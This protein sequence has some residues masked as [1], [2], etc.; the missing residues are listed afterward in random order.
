MTDYGLLMAEINPLII[1]GDG[2]FIALDGK[3]EVDDNFVDLT[4]EME[5]FY[6]REHASTEENEARDAGLSFVKLPVGS[7]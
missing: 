6:Q 1:S 4:A 3:V 5:G 7:G 2:D